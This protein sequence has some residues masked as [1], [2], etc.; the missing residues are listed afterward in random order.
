MILGALLDLGVPARIVREGLRALGLGGVRLSV[1]RVRRGPIAARYVR[2]GVPRRLDR[3]RT[4]RQIR[5]ALLRSRLS[6]AVRERSL[7]VFEALA[8]AEARIHG[9]SVDRVHFHEVGAVD[10]IGDVVGSCLALEHLGAERITASPLPLGQ[11]S[12]ESDHGRLPLPA[13]AALELL[14]GAPTY[15][16]GI[17]EETVT[18]TGAAIIAALADGFGPLP[19][20]VPERIGYGA[21]DDREQ[22]LPNVLRAVLGAQ[23]SVLETD[24]VFVLETNLD[25]MSP[26]HLP[27]LVERLLAEGS[28]DVTLTPVLMKKGRPGYVL[29]VL[30]A[31]SD[32]DRLARRV[33]LD[34]TAIG[35][36]AYEAAR[37]KLPRSTRTVATRFGRVRVK[38]VRG[39]D[40]RVAAS[41]EYDSCRRLA[42]RRDVP[43]VAVYREAERVALEGSG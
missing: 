38:M 4:Y 29:R 3:E 42:L 26:E 21:G 11:G 16:A 30:A 18:P 33:L 19:T 7:R 43:L 17:R 27:F 6:R 14:R 9:I 28:L 40:G 12:V 15:P 22:P 24:T 35:V 25:D 37:L 10:A 32:R 23:G 39:L 36:R 5:A 13:P 34:S 20:F 1:E 8:R 2:F 31:P 41:P